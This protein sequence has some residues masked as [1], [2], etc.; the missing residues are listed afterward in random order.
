MGHVK[1]EDFEFSQTFS[2]TTSI[3]K[4]D[5]DN[6]ILF[7]QTKI[8]LLENPQLA[9]K[10][11]IQAMMLPGRC[12]L[13]RAQGEMTQLPVFS[14][15]IMILYGV[16]GDPDWNHRNTRLMGEL[17]AGEELHVKYKISEK[18]ED[19][20]YGILAIDFE[21]SKVKDKKVV[22]MPR[23]NLSRVKK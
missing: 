16:D 14:N 4:Q 2:L 13:S 7:A 3:I 19:K 22:V 15:C 9:E 5:F 10:E 12:M 18:R 17:Y 21:I 11:G 23:R 20:N 8:V 1:F 6:Y